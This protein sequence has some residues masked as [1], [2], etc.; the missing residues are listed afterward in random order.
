MHRRA[1]VAVPVLAAVLVVAPVYARIRWRWRRVLLPVRMPLGLPAVGVILRPVLLDAVL[2]GRLV[3]WAVVRQCG[4]PRPVRT[5]RRIVGMRSRVVR[6]MVRRWPRLARWT[7]WRLPRPL[8]GISS[9]AT[10]I[11]G[12]E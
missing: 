12:A 9:A 7:V 6:W 3:A 5:M 2:P 10:V 11:A 8:R 1:P 4:L